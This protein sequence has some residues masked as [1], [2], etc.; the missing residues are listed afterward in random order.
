[1]DAIIGKDGIVRQTLLGL[2]MSHKEGQLQT[3]TAVMFTNT[4]G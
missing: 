3:F 2:K 4:K 1:M